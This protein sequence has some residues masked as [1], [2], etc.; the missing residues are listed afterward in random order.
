MKRKQM[1]PVLLLIVLVALLTGCYEVK[2]DVQVYPTGEALL[3]H[4]VTIPTMAVNMRLKSMSISA[5]DMRKMIEQQA[6]QDAVQIGETQLVD[7]TIRQGPDS[8]TITR[9]FLFA[10]AE[11]LSAYFELLGLEAK[12]KRGCF[13]H[14][15]AVEAPAVD[16]GKVVRLGKFYEPPPKKEQVITESFATERSFTLRVTMPGSDKKVEPESEKFGNAWEWKIAEERYPEPLAVDYQTR[17]KKAKLPPLGKPAT[18]DFAVIDRVLTGLPGDGAAEF[19][20][21]F[22]ARLTPVLHLRLDKRDRVDLS[23]L[24]RADETAA[25]AADYHRQVDTLTAPDFAAAYFPYVE[26][27]ELDG[28]RIVA[29]GFRRR[30][31]CKAKELTGALRVERDGKRQVVVL[32]TP[33]MYRGAGAKAGPPERVVAV[34]V[35]TFP[36]GAQQYRVI[37]V[38]DLRAGKAIRISG[39]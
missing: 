31:P 29:E 30:A 26:A 20:R 7:A 17:R 8:T 18:S 35:V 23:L 34:L 32:Q 5:V 15:F 33:R 2:V 14:K 13:R 11:H 36:D 16:E 1:I 22:G 21:R 28:G 37:T 9:R 38:A 12:Y 4:V 6:E 27:L 39:H 25:Q 19:A 10:E 24:W 3:T